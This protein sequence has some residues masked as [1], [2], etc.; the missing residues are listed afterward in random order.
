MLMRQ[1]RTNLRKSGSPVA[2]YY[3][4]LFKWLVPLGNQ[5]AEGVC[6]FSILGM[7]DLFGELVE[8]ECCANHRV[9]VLRARSSLLR[10]QAHAARRVK[11]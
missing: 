2:A 9:I 1:F 5:S 11:A 3:Q 10:I 6:R 7:R 4:N 8:G